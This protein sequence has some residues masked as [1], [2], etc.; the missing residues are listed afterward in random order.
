[1]TIRLKEFF[2]KLEKENPYE[3]FLF[4]KLYYNPNSI[5]SDSEEYVDVGFYYD[6]DAAYKYIFNN[7][8]LQFLD[9]AYNDE[10]FLNK[11]N[12]YLFLSLERLLEISEDIATIVKFNDLTYSSIYEYIKLR[13]ENRNLYKYKDI[14]KKIK[15]YDLDLADNIL[16]RTTDIICIYELV[17]TT[18]NKKLEN[19]NKNIIYFPGI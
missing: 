9:L 8:L 13:I 5:F 16:Q 18:R 14:T 1:M 12:Y 3:Y 17:D 15:K 2:N 10:E 6:E 7:N 19:N 11:M 4:K